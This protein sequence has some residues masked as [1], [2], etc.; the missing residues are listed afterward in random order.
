MAPIANRIIPLFAAFLIIIAAVAALAQ[1]PGRKIA[2]IE[3]EGLQRLSADEVIATTGLKTGAPFSLENLDQG[4]QKLVDSGQFSK[5]GYRTATTK[6]LVTIVFQVVESKGGSS[7]VVYDNFVWFTNDELVA[8]IRREVPAFDGSA[9]NAGNITDRIREAL[10]NLLK[11]KE[12]EGTVDYAPTEI[13]EHLYSVTGVHIR[14]CQLH[15][16]GATNVPEEKLVIRSRQLVED[17][18][19]LKGAVAFTHYI[20]YPIY[21]E[22][23][24]WR[25]KFAEP[26]FKVVDERDCKRGIDL[27][28][29]VNEGPIYMWDKA[30]W[31]GNAVLTPIQ[32]DATLGLK[33]GDLA[34][35]GKFDKGLHNLHQR[36]GLTGYLDVEFAAK[37]EFDDAASRMSVKITVQEG[38]QYHM[39]KLTVKGVTAADVVA[40]EERWKLKR[41]D[42]FDTS[43][44]ERF[45][46]TDGRE[47]L[48]KIAA[49][50]QAQGKR[51]P[52]IGFQTTPN[53]TTVLADVTLEFKDPD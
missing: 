51:P 24:Q 29:P 45:L 44:P 50:W 46:K 19:S 17:S 31:I 42:V 20:L 33:N 3:I 6:N 47:V 18:F 11:E 37:P 10:Q 28:I 5:V 9:P 43:Y 30:E 52:A 13:G 4:A 39:G 14:I 15:F 12:I 32:L 27:S 23:G 16:P 2:R 53:R 36:Y 8:A 35:G 49:A 38:P 7:K 34:N 41:G 48:Q 26:A 22:A 21:R 40:L 1:A 25:A